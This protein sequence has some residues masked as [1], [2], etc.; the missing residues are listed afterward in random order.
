MITKMPI[1]NGRAKISRRGFSLVELIV[2]MVVTAI[3]AAVAI[4]ATTPLTST[5]QK[6]AARQLTR[7]LGFARE[8]SI[9]TGIRM[10]VT[11]SPSADTYTMLQELST[12]PGRASATAFTDPA[13]GRPFL[14]QLNFGDFIGV[15]LSTVTIGTGTEIGFD[16]LG[17]PMDSSSTLLS[18]SG[19]INI[20]GATITIHPESGL[21]TWQ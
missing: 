9:A 21:A 6:I 4:P 14:Q 10:W 15:D 18:G 16:W 8:R 13:T 2:V 1:P 7:D 19:T 12:A 20:S 11:L 17:R 5:R 3:I